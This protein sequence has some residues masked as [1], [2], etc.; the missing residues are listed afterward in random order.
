MPAPP[1]PSF[2][3]TGTRFAALSTTCGAVR[4]GAGGPR[5]ALA[6]LAAR[7]AALEE[8][9]RA[10]DAAAPPPAPPAT[11]LSQAALFDLYARVGLDE[12]ALR[13]LSLFRVPPRLAVTVAYAAGV[14]LGLPAVAERDSWPSSQALLRRADFID[15]V[16]AVDPAALPPAARAELARLIARDK[17]DDF[18]VVNDSSGAAA[19]LMSWVKAVAA[20]APPASAW[21]VERAALT[22]ALAAAADELARARASC[23]A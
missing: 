17:L 19:N 5:A 3:V 18:S 8:R 9:L 1:Q 12:G 2:E 10:G 11:R 16:F 13:E 7:V 23:A 4:A 21:D 14:I 20:A 15:R 6:S 22:A